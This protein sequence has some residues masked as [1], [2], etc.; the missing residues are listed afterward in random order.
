ML[1]ALR[2]HDLTTQD[3]NEVW[4]AIGSNDRRPKVNG[5]PLKVL[6]YGAEHFDLGL[7]EHVV[8]GTWLRVYSV[9]RT[10]VDLFR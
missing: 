1:S 10:V 2:F 5:T 7:E 9:A 3:P 8:E 4:S 6:R